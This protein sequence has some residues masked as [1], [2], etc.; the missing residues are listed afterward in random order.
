MAVM[1]ASK[2]NR[3][4]F[5]ARFA[6][7]GSQFYGVQEQPGL[8]TVLGALR[9]RIEAAAKQKACALVATAR[10]DRGVHALENYA[11]FYLKEDFDNDAFLK[12]FAAPLDDGLYSLEVKPVSE[13]VHARGSA[14]SKV[15]RYYLQ[16]SCMEEALESPFIWKIAPALDRQALKE[17][18]SYLIG[19]MDFSSLRGGGCQAGSPVKEI[20]RLEIVELCDGVIYVEIEGNGFL[21]KMIRNLVGLLAEVGAGLRKPSCVPIVLAKKDREA[22]GIMAPPHGLFLQ[23]IVLKDGLN[24][25]TPARDDIHFGSGI[26]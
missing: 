24:L 11:S 19:K 2:Y 7:D 9:K 10:T 8:K 13:K 20:Y 4:Q 5:L 14:L 1:M 21:R 6:Y 17:A 3:K 26:F 16:D 25:M 22:S 15:Y 18:S 12:D 23:S